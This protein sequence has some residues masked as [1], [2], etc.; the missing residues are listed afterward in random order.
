MLQKFNKLQNLC[1]LPVW[2]L[3]LEHKPEVIYRK[4]FRTGVKEEFTR[5]SLVL[6][7][8]TVLSFAYIF[9]DTVNWHG[10]DDKF[11]QNFDR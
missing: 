4:W 3:F 6:V 10:T 8:N 7:E 1:L 11:I 5:D 2:N 9:N